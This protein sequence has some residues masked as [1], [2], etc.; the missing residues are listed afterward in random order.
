MGYEP[1]YS[2]TGG[3]Y[4][5][6]S[7]KQYECPSCGERQ[8]DPA[9]HGWDDRQFDPRIGELARYFKETVKEYRSR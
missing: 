5:Y 6:E 2:C 1:P 4:W 8:R 3:D 7:E 9:P